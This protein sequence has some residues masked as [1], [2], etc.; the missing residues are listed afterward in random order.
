MVDIGTNFVY[1]Q[2]ALNCD[3]K[4]VFEVRWND[5]HKWGGEKYGK[6]TLLTLWK[7]PN[8]RKILCSRGVECVVLVVVRDPLVWIKAMTRNDYRTYYDVKCASKSGRNCWHPVDKTFTESTMYNPDNGRPPRKRIWDSIAFG[9][10]DFYAPYLDEGNKFKRFFIRYEDMLVH[11][12]EVTSS[13][14]KCFTGKDIGKDEFK[15]RTKTAKNHGSNGFLSNED[16]NNYYRLALE[17]YK[18][19]NSPEGRTEGYDEHDLD[20]LRKN[21]DPRLMKLFNYTV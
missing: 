1:K 7:D 15:L 11:P 14:C 19:E 2:L 12:Y 4:A 18:K 9:W 16:Y 21:L 8:D 17:K 5:I 6:H 10:N 3:D 20:Y 13:V